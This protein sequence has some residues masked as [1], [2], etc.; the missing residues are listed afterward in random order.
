MTRDQGLIRLRPRF[1]TSGTMAEA[2]R[3]TLEAEVHTPGPSISATRG[4]GKMK[5]EMVRI[6]VRT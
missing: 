5:Q 4:A 1:G 2:S 3:Q 6:P